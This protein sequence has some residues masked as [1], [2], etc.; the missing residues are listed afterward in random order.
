MQEI[1]YD[2]SE[3]LG[4]IKRVFGSQGAFAK[5][6]GMAESTLSLKLNN[7]AEWS[8]DEMM[9]AVTLLQTD[10]GKVRPYFFTHI[11]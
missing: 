8:Q 7:R 9:L 3:I 1:K 2:Y 4:D 11:V 5:A 6:M 10:V